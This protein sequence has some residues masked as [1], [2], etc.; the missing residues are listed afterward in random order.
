MKRLRQP[1]LWL[2][3]AVAWQRTRNRS[4][5]WYVFEA[6]AHRLQKSLFPSPPPG[7][8]ELFQSGEYPSLTRKQLREE[9]GCWGFMDANLSGSSLSRHKRSPFYLLLDVAV[10]S[11]L[12]RPRRVRNLSGRIGEL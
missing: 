7:G 11:R 1:V 2:G 6:K 3:L 12:R 9:C 8:V 5:H 10:E 4:H